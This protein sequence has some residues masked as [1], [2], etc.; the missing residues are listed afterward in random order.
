MVEKGA[1]INKPGK[2]KN[3]PLHVASQNGHFEIVKFLVEKGAVLNEAGE[4]KNTPLHEAVKNNQIKIVRWLVQKYKFDNH[5]FYKSLF[6]ATQNG[7]L[8]ILKYLHQYKRDTIAQS[9][10]KELVLQAIQMG[11]T[12]I[13]KY[14][15]GCQ[16]GVAIDDKNNLLREA[17]KHSRLELVEVLLKTTKSIDVNDLL[18]LAVTKGGR[19][20]AD[21]FISKKYG[22][23]SDNDGCNGLHLAAEKEKNNCKLIN[24]IVKLYSKKL[25]SRTKSTDKTALHIAIL[26][27]NHNFVK[28]LLDEGADIYAEYILENSSDNIK[29][30]TPFMLAVRSSRIS[31]K[32]II[33]NDKFNLNSVWRPS[34]ETKDGLSPLIYCAK[35]GCPELIEAL[36]DKAEDKGSL[37]NH[38]NKSGN[39]A[40]HIAVDRSDEPRISETL[41][42]LGANPGIKNNIGEN[43]VHAAAHSNSGVLKY[44]INQ[45]PITFHMGMKWYFGLDQNNW[46]K[47]FLAT[48]NDKRNVLHFACASTSKSSIEQLHGW[49]N[50]MGLSYMTPDQNEKKPI[51]YAC[52]KEVKNFVEKK[53]NETGGGGIFPKLLYCTYCLGSEATAQVCTQILASKETGLTAKTAAASLLIACNVAD[54]CAGKSSKSAELVAKETGNIIGRSIGG[55]ITE[56]IKEEVKKEK[57]KAKEE[58]KKKVK[59]EEK[60]EVKKEVKEEEKKEAGEKEN[61]GSASIFS[62]SS[63]PDNTK[64]R[65]RSKSG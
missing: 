5:H 52:S 40:L 33:K 57:K 28:A 15:M 13:F 39:T 27:D 10:F 60:K 9:G 8:S 65:P 55:E 24:S 54:Q 30:K 25:E 16:E 38:K 14:L 44:M 17:V 62:F 2:D 31:T 58:A 45:I 51:D 41:I 64:N 19:E 59:E 4:D 43:P 37:L 35:Y 61:L 18:N 6:I 47:A 7:H 26:H 50:V 12:L 22:S 63:K 20:I 34:Y 3:T 48:T 21:L 36:V 11:H 49:L 32:V 42:K 56:K 46:V 23:L 29:V 1:E 53:T